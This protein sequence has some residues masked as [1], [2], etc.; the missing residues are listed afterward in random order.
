MYGVESVRNLS[1]HNP[2]RELFV[3]ELLYSGNGSELDPQDY[4]ELRY[5]IEGTNF[6]D[7]L[8]HYA[9]VL[10]GKEYHQM[11][12][13]LFEK[14]EALSKF[15]TTLCTAE[16]VKTEDLITRCE[17]AA[18][19]EQFWDLY[20]CLKLHLRVTSNNAS[21]NTEL[22]KRILALEKR[23]IME[24]GTV[25]SDA[26]LERLQAFGLD[27][28]TVRSAQYVSLYRH[29]DDGNPAEPAVQCKKAS[30][31][32]RFKMVV[33]SMVY[34]G[35]IDVFSL[36]REYKKDAGILSCVGAE[37]VEAA[38][39]WLVQYFSHV[40]NDDLVLSFLEHA[41]RTALNLAANGCAL[42]EALAEMKQCTEIAKE[43]AVYKKETK[44]IV[45]Y[46]NERCKLLCREEQCNGEC[47]KED[48]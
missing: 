23:Y 22:C 11:I 30:I 35:R 10:E 18:D 31:L 33:R 27:D 16:Q 5:E 47:K 9:S 45:D 39:S 21:G 41:S 29:L 4:E 12:P 7:I 37:N 2:L 3:E 17:L 25:F 24:T 40:R 42:D 46:V 36:Y 1:V 19:V 15:Y 34:V 28:G 20:Y 38:K 6:T 26:S 44:I 13:D 32:N 48:G 8:V 43:Q 14:R